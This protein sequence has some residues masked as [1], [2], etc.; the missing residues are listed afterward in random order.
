MNSWF[1][2]FPHSAKFVSNDQVATP[3]FYFIFFQI[4]AYYDFHKFFKTAAWRGYI[5]HLAHSLDADLR[6]RLLLKQTFHLPCHLHGRISSMAKLCQDLGSIRSPWRAPRPQA[7][8]VCVQPAAAP[9][10]FVCAAQHRPDSGPSRHG[11]LHTD[12]G[13]GLLG[14]RAFL[15]RALRQ[16]SF[17]AAFCR[18]NSQ[19]WESLPKNWPVPLS[20]DARKLNWLTKSLL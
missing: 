9:R 3:T 19:L 17:P 8:P 4:T 6:A 1:I 12:M 14:V 16:P 18:Q 11:G 10:P 2:K 15:Q 20:E 13:W 7:G 5:I